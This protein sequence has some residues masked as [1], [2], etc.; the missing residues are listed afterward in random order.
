MIHLASRYLRDIFRWNHCLRIPESHSKHTQTNKRSSDGKG[1]QN[2]LLMETYLNVV[3]QSNILF[4]WGYSRKLLSLHKFFFIFVV[5]I[6][7]SKRVSKF[8]STSL[9]LML[10]NY[11][12]KVNIVW[13]EVR[14]HMKRASLSIISTL[15]NFTL[16]HCN[17]CVDRASVQDKNEESQML[18]VNSVRKKKKKYYLN[19]L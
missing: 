6:D 7:T 13:D 15:G 10:N 18:E 19:E 2:T 8:L 14:V 16:L 11:C 3:I 1:I 5:A 4:W 17:E 12:K 9:Q